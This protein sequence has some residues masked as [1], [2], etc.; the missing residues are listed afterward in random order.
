MSKIT[1]SEFVSY[2]GHNISANG[3]V[4]LALA[5]R[6]GEL[7]NTIQVMQ[8][9]NEDI[10]IKARLGSNKPMILGTFRIKNIMIDGDGESKIKLAS[11]RDAVELDNLNSLPFANEDNSEFAIRMEANVEDVEDEAGSDED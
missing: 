10:K 5:A 9:L 11:T 4:N 3:V 8:L 6:Y 1:I 7:K 2:S